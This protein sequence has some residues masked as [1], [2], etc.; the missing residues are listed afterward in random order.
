ML[1]KNDCSPKI[2]LIT[3]AARR[4]GAEIARVLHADNINVVVH[5]HQSQTEAEQL[6][7]ELNNKRANSAIAL[8]ASLQYIQD[9]PFLV[10]CAAESWGRLDI[11]INNAAVFYKTFIGEV[12]EQSWDNLLDCNVKAPFF[13]SQAAKPYLEESQGCIVN[14]GDIRAE[15]PLRDYPVYCISKA[16][17]T[18]LTKV[19]A[20]ELGPKIRV[21]AVAPGPT[22][23]PEGEN[24]LSTEIKERI[25]NQTV[26]K[27]A[28]NPSNVAV[29]VRYLVNQADYVTG[30][31]IAVDGGRSL[32]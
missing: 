5:Y 32:G 25:I 17:L 4:I 13:L 27:K 30:Q 14:I 8:Q 31:V 29:A 16:G 20:Y 19:L 23:W 21:N 18:M 24:A 9:F 7:A 2:A 10:R 26:L 1:Y 11:L 28:G 12:T 3:G 22:L 6:I 15:K